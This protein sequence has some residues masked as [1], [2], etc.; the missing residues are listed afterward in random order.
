MKKVKIAAL[1][2][3]LG[4]L[5]GCASSYPMG[6]LFTEVTLP[7]GATSNADKGSKTG[8]AECLSV[9][10]LVATGDCS[11]AAAKKEGKISKVTHVDWYARNILGIIG[12]YKVIVH[13]E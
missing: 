2:L 10:S 3:A 11:I 8:T 13:G 5:S 9:L 12:N 7:A 1:L 6:L 4:M